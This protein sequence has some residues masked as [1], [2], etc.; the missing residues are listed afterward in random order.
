MYVVAIAWVY[1]MMLVALTQPTLMR[2]VLTFLGAGLA[3]LALW[4]WLMG[5]PQRRRD[6]ARRAAR[7]SDP[8]QVDSVDPDR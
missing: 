6:R 4:L 5:T 7:E 2:G 1:V 8:E 3:P